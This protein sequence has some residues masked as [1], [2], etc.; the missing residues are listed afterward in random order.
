[1]IEKLAAPTELWGR[2]RSLGRDSTYPA[3]NHH[4]GHGPRTHN[5]RGAGNNGEARENYLVSSADPQAASA[6]SRATLPLHTAT[7]YAQ[8]ISL[9]NPF[10]SFFTKGPSEEIQPV[11]MHSSRTEGANWRQSSRNLTALFTRSRLRASR[12]SA[13][14]ERLPGELSSNSHPSVMTQ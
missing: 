14:I 12:G 10:S 13:S 1:M 9:A 2:R 4:N 5:R 6:T 11:S 8:P 7:P 3:D